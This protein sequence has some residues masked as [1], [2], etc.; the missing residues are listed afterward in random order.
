MTTE[1]ADEHILLKLN[2]TSSIQTEELAQ[3]IDTSQ[4][5]II[6]HDTPDSKRHVDVIQIQET[7]SQTDSNSKQKDR[8]D[9]NTKSGGSSGGDRSFEIVSDES[10]PVQWITSQ[11]S[12]VTS[13][14]S[15]EPASPTSS[16]TP[17]T[18]VH[19]DVKQLVQT[20][21]SAQDS[22]QQ[23]QMTTRRPSPVT[24]VS[25]GVQTDFEQQ[26]I[27]EPK[28]VSSKTQDGFE[29]SQAAVNTVTTSLDP[30]ASSFD[31]DKVNNQ[32]EPNDA[33]TSQLF[34]EIIKN[35]KDEQ[36]DLT[37]S[38]RRSLAKIGLKAIPSMHGPLSLP[39][40]RCPSGIDAFVFSID[41]D[42]DPYTFLIEDDQRD[43]H[44]GQTFKVQKVPL[45]GNARY[46]NGSQHKSQSQRIVSAPTT[47]PVPL[48]V[49]APPPPPLAR[50]PVSAVA[51]GALR[52]TRKDTV[53][54]RS[55]SS[56]SVVRRK[57]HRGGK[58]RT[59]HKT[60][61]DD[62]DKIIEATEAKE[63]A[64]FVSP[65][66]VASPPMHYPH[67]YDAAHYIQPS[68]KF[69]VEVNVDAT[70]SPRQI[71]PMV[72]F[73]YWTLPMQGTA[74]QPLA[75]WDPNT[76]AHY[77]YQVAAAQH[78]HGAAFYPSPPSV[79]PVQLQQLNQPQSTM[80]DPS[81]ANA[82]SNTGSQTQQLPQVYAA[83]VETYAA[84]QHFQ[85][86]MQQSGVDLS[87]IPPAELLRLSATT[88]PSPFV[89]QNLQQPQSQKTYQQPTN[90][91]QHE[92]DRANSPVYQAVAAAQLAAAAATSSQDVAHGRVPSL[93]IEE[94][95]TTIEDHKPRR[96][97]SAAPMVPVIGA[98]RIEHASPNLV[99]R[100]RRSSISSAP[101]TQTFAQEPTSTTLLLP[102]TPTTPL[103]S[104]TPAM[105]ID[106]STS[107]QPLFMSHDRIYSPSYSTNKQFLP[108]KNS[109]I[110]MNQSLNPSLMNMSNQQQ[111]YIN[112]KDP[113]AV[114]SKKS[115][116]INEVPIQ[117]HQHDRQNSTS[118]IKSFKSLMNYPVLNQFNVDNF[119][120]NSFGNTSRTRTESWTD[121]RSDVGLTVK[122]TTAQMMREPT[123]RVESGAGG[124]GGTSVGGKKRQGWRG[125]KRGG[126][127]NH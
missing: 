99:P 11:S 101:F 72:P 113:P 65:P 100:L 89:Y 35:G 68:S 81:S 102:P 91:S 83:A 115:K 95:D 2:E 80:R 90:S 97:R 39:Y 37:K 47:V 42:E 23:S 40:A 22:A 93:R 60:A 84:L 71:Q 88:T 26:K 111:H 58:A 1:K 3:Q 123:G 54:A 82:S 92:I 117:S 38:A 114:V 116:S 55:S 34:I 7:P 62:V 30:M 75:A 106:S 87:A 45:P 56:T 10:S 69:G 103:L 32:S 43:L 67:H 51:S 44:Q 9:S 70:S 13:V 59:A 107:S 48:P 104:I 118:S 17:T 108:N 66:T 112:F 86:A 76:L 79:N 46:A 53:D 125:R 25:T 74:H 57:S 14:S 20:S 109:S 8:V 61:R 77:Q 6:I 49:S 36:G 52:S 126:Q 124:G 33:E 28:D 63:N 18:Q 5:S 41:K 96:R 16:K 31:P 4:S 110:E 64:A 50:Q 121:N 120:Q 29:S 19:H 94:E 24:I 85:D 127:N 105:D 15:I 119:D 21:K 78:P 73:P 98:N 122:N 27:D 12:R